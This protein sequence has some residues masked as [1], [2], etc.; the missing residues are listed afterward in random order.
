MTEMIGAFITLFWILALLAVGVLGTIFLYQ[1]IRRRTK[2][3]QM[4][5]LE[6]S[7]SGYNNVAIG[8]AAKTH[9]TRHR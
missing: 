1:Y 4:Q 9:V 3:D 8:R 2:E 7:S 6:K 5:R